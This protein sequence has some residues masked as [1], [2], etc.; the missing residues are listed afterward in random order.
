M[1]MID[2]QNISIMHSHQQGCAVF[3]KILIAIYMK[4]KNNEK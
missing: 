3:W 2:L 1:I 4:K